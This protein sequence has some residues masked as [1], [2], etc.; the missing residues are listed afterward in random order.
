[1]MSNKEFDEQRNNLLSN[2]KVLLSSL[3]G[4]K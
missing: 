3:K 2:E 1:M 4:V